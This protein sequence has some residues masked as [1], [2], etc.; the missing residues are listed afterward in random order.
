MR[1]G[2][3]RGALQSGTA[4][5]AAAAAAAAVGGGGGG[6]EGGGK[7]EKTRYRVACHFSFAPHTTNEIKRLDFTRCV[8]FSASLR[9]KMRAGLREIAPTRDLRRGAAQHLTRYR[10]PRDG[11]RR[12]KE[13]C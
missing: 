11:K 3:G 10:E 2:G 8:S 9:G 4:A 5:A 6:R 1:G 12:R 7:V 13:T